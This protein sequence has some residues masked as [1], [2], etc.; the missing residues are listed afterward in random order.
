MAADKDT[1]ELTAFEEHLD[2]HGSRAESWP[3]EARRRF[4]PLIAGNARARELLA[5]AR[6][7]EDLLDRAPLP[8]PDRMRTLSDQIV[9]V[10]VAERHD[11]SAPAPVIDLAARRQARNIARPAFWRVASALAASLLV[12]IYLG[13]SPPIASAIEAIAGAVG[14]QTETENTDLAVIYD[15]AADEEE[16]L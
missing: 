2:V 3:E 7:L 10:A 1:A 16:Y 12:G 5:A 14:V 6:A 11:Q 15:P 4:E 9:S 8:S 13:A